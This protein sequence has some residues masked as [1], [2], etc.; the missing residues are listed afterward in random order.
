MYHFTGLRILYIWH[1]KLLIYPDRF[2]SSMLFIY[3]PRDSVIA[4]VAVPDERSGY[5][6]SNDI[7]LL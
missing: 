2:I 5:I 3:S 7:L 1:L 4:D 6:L